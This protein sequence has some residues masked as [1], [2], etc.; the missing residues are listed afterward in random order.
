MSDTLI[1]DRS[2]DDRYGE[3]VALSPL[4][5]RVIAHN[6]GPFTFNG[7]GTHIIGRGRVAILDPGPHDAA[8]VAALLAAVEG[9][10]VDY[11]VVT[12]TH[13]DHI[14]ALPALALATGAQ[15]V[16]AA[17]RPADLA[18]TPAEAVKYRPDRVMA[19]GEMIAGDGWSIEA[20]PTPGHTA[21]HLAFGLTEEGSIF[22][23]D[24]VMAWSTTVVLPPDGSMSDYT[25]SLKALLERDED[26]YYPAHGP[27]LPG[28][29]NH[30]A[31]LLRH[32][33]RREEY[34]LDR[35]ACG[36]RT[37]ADI[38]VSLYPGL[39]P[40]LIGGARM[41]VFAHLRDLVARG[42]VRTDGDPELDGAYEMN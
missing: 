11:I 34:I 35:V 16:G 15:I 40:R 17:P 4:V 14:G 37:I 12:H 38:V 20:I 29:R 2:F 42:M 28:A 36:D 33:E 7:T 8:H 3:A 13:L 18:A 21:N 41:S 24:H 6:P 22:P 26:H 39:D 31:G 9:E 10:H 23:G 32:R 5:R 25:R 19:Q 30:V 1:F 27:V